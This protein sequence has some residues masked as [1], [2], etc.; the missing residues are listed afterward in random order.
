MKEKER[1]AGH[2]G[3]EHLQSPHVA[4]K[5]SLPEAALIMHFQ[6]KRF[7]YLLW[8]RTQRVSS[9]KT[10]AGRSL[11]VHQAIMLFHCVP[12]LKG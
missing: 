11:D 3:K 5:L 4:A 2:R 6:N 9:S 10:E 12:R 7:I 8:K 1:S